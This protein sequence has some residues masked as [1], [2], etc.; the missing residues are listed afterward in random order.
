MRQHFVADD[1]IA[2]VLNDTKLIHNV[3]FQTRF[4]V[5]YPASIAQGTR[6]PRLGNNGLLTEQSIERILYSSKHKGLAV[7]VNRW[8]FPE[9]HPNHIQ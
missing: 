2:K 3:L 7:D 1:E 4:H 6:S 8:L 5:L 9:I